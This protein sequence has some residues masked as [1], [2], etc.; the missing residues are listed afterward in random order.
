MIKFSC[1]QCGQ[2]LE[3]DSATAGAAANCP[4][5]NGAV[6]VPKAP[7][8]TAG[9][10]SP[11]ANQPVTQP[12][13]TAA[14]DALG[15]DHGDAFNM[16]DGSV[17]GLTST[18]K[19]AVQEFKRLDY[20]FLVPFSKFFGSQML[21]KKAVRWVLLFGLMPLAIFQ[22][23][24]MADLDFD[25]VIWMIEL[26]F[27][28]FWA[29]YFYS[30]IQPSRATWKRGVLYGA[31]TAVVGI[32]LL[33]IAQHLPIV[34]NLYRGVGSYSDIERLF[35]FIFGVGI[36]E[37]TCKALPLLLFALRDKSGLTLREATF[38]GLMSGLGFAAAEGVQY[39][40]NVSAAAAAHYTPQAATV[41]ITQFLHRIMSGPI[42][43][44][45]WAGTAAW[46]IGVASV[47]SGKK[48]PVIVLG[49]GASAFLH[50]LYD[51]FSDGILGI[52][53]AAVTFLVF[54]VYLTHGDASAKPA[55]NWTEAADGATSGEATN[56]SQSTVLPGVDVTRSSEHE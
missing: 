26:Y 24:R 38:L 20:G 34:R 4:A 35:G 43:H 3:A 50:G 55:I 8:Q 37:E 25:E 27:C 32:P 6:I 28:L 51:F 12:E 30:L 44:A 1:G 45:A 49:I 31:F 42:L 18:V 23:Y 46:F 33:L 52:G 21:R 29:L 47:R 40:V 9:P 15:K 54:L 16:E 13:G 14:H 22:V 10:A 41:Q 48:W 36:M 5:C 2:S 17:I 7:E 56:A 11:T 19:E 53:L 39:T